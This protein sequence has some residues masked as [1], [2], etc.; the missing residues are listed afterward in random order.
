MKKICCFAVMAMLA[1]I[2]SSCRD[3][4]WYSEFEGSWESVYGVD[5]YGEYDIYG[6]D[7]VRYDFYRDGKGR[8][9][10]YSSYGLSFID[11]DWDVRGHRL[12]INYYDGTYEDL[13]Y[14]HDRNGYIMLSPSPSFYT[15]VAYRRVF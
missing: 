4:P 10:Y 15:Y 5:Q 1:M 11:F 14:G 12:Y 3:E 6:S 8:Y 13:Y 7:V 9:T 2:V